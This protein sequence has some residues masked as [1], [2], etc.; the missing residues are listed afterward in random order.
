M[1]Y[2]SILI[3]PA[4]SLC[5]MACRYC[6]YH[7]VAE[8]REVK[9]YGI[10][11]RDVAE[12]MLE[13]IFR[14]AGDSTD[15]TFLFQGGEPTVAGLQFFKDFIQIVDKYNEN[16]LPVHYGI[17]TN[18]YLIDEDW[19]RFLADHHFL[20]G[21]SQDGPRDIH[22]FCRPDA[23]GKGTF[24]RTVQAICLFNEYKI[25]YNILSVITKQFAR[26]PQAVWDY[27]RRSGIKYVQLIP[28]LKP[29]KDGRADPTDLTP[30]MYG[31]F[32]KQF[33]RLW[34]AAFLRGEYLSVRQFDNL[35]LMLRG[36]PP[37]QC[38]LSGRCT[39][40]FVVEADGSVYPCDFYTLDEY[41]C[42]NAAQQP[43]EEIGASEGMRRFLRGETPVGELCP[44]CEVRGL[45]G[46]GCRRYRS[47]YTL[48]SGYCPQQ[49][50][51]YDALPQLLEIARQGA[52]T[53]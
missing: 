2:F 22:D 27:Y 41:R 23:S 53:V 18:G 43:V 30:R 45:C 25:D 5:N 34:Y 15:L 37:E 7:D 46:G 1:K 19:C 8:N 32:M 24:S 10:M 16:R 6:F 47:F 36:Q 17:Q 21:L 26:H 31:N 48:E 9:S 14:Y 12:R 40:Q 29:L 49:D 52:H 51:L 20:V 3:K 39:P 13:N 44:S 42:G 33:F 38:G 50:F 35:V 11:T 4:S 28:C